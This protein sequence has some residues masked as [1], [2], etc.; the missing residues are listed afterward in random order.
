MARF[1]VVF[2]A[3]VLYPAPL[4]DSL[5]R[6]AN[7][8]LFKAYWTDQIHDEWINAL[9]REGK[10][11]RESLERVRELMDRHV[12]DA[13]VTGYEKLIEGLELPDSNDRHVLAAAIKSKA[14]A[15]VTFNLKDFPEEYLTSFHIEVIHPDD[16]I[17]YQIDM[18]PAACCSAFRDQRN[19]LKKPKINVDDFLG[20]LQKQQLPQTVSLLRQ[21][22][23]LI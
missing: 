14:D 7:K 18:A 6:L 19:A 11:I 8:D 3:C 15:I 9:V 10:Y 16:F 4:R 5:M 13:K 2:D 17:Y 23:Q 1:S 21:Y 22:S 20:H 12:P